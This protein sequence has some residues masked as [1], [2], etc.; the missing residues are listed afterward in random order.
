MFSPV[1]LGFYTDRVAG[2]H[3]HHSAWAVPLRVAKA[4]T[5]AVKTLCTSNGKQWGISLAMYPS[6]FGRLLPYNPNGFRICPDDAQISGTITC[7]KTAA[8][9]ERKRAARTMFY[10]ALRKF[11]A[12]CSKKTTSP[13]IMSHYSPRNTTI[14]GR[15]GDEGP[16]NRPMVL[17]IEDGSRVPTLGRPFP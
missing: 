7:S 6:Q 10:S 8:A 11:G 14:H 13:P 4:K 15:L 9:P 16:G 1:V 5:K 3:R 12:G 2:R 17:P